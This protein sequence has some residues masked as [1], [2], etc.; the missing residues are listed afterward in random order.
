MKKRM[1]QAVFSSFSMKAHAAKVTTAVVNGGD[2]AK[3]TDAVRTVYSKEIEFKA[4]PNMRFLV[5]I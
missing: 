1:L 4:L 5:Y 3:F 2:N